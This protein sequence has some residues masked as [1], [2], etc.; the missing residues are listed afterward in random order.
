MV[1]LSNHEGRPRTS[2]FDKLR[3]RSSEGQRRTFAA[4]LTVGAVNPIGALMVSLSNHEGGRPDLVLRQAQDEV[5]QG[6]APHLAAAL[7]VGVGNPHRSPHGEPVEPRGRVP[8][9]TARD[10]TPSPLGRPQQRLDVILEQ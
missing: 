6:E 8:G 2:S 10:T 7:T 9:L 5:L 3:M 4:A 1:S